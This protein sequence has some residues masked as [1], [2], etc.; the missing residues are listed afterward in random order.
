MSLKK[1]LD[2]QNMVGIISLIASNFN[3]EKTKMLKKTVLFRCCRFHAHEFENANNCWH[4]HI[5]EHDKFDAP[6]N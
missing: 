1:T 5:Y 6:L 2:L 3:C 4:F